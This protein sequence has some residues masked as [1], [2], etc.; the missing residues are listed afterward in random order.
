MQPKRGERMH[1]G[2]NCRFSL[3]FQDKCRKLA[4]RFLE[5]DDLI[6]EKWI[7]IQDA[8]IYLNITVN[9]LKGR[10][11]TGQIKTKKSSTGK[12]TLCVSAA[13]QY[14]DCPL[15]DAG[16]QCLFYEPH[17]ERKISCLA[18][19]EGIK[20]E[21]PNKNLLPSAEELETFT[22]MIANLTKDT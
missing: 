13:W 2:Y 9:D 12:I 20:G 8:V 11:G 19:R 22:E 1:Y 5:R 15:A 7:S 14:D 3:P 17:D 18:E 6:E 16:G 21:H 4:D 10:I